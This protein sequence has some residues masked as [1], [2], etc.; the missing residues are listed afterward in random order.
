V[1]ETSIEVANDLS[2]MMQAVSGEHH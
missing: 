2:N 1:L